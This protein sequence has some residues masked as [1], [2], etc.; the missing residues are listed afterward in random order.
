LSSLTY[1]DLVRE[2]F[3]RLT[4]GIRWGLERTERMLEAVGRPQDRFRA[5]HIGGTN[6]KG[7]V[8]AMVDSVLREAGL[9]TGLYTSPHLCS[10]RERVQIDGGAIGEAE[11]VAAAARLW[12]MIV[13]ESASFFEATTAIAFL[14]L[15]DADVDVAVIEVGLGGRLD[16]TNVVGPEVTVLTNVALDHVQLLGPTIESIARE[17]AGIIKCG[18]P[19]VTG[20]TD[21]I[22]LAIFQAAA[23]ACGTTLFPAA[24]D[25]VEAV[26]T[27][28]RG[29]ALTV[30]TDAWDRLGIHV[31]LAGSHQAFNAA[32]AVRT[33]ERLP[34]DLRPGPDVVQAGLERV[35]WLGRLQVETAAGRTWVFDVAHNM[36]GVQALT[37]AMADLEL[38]RPLVG[39][40]GVLGDKDWRAMLAPVYGFCDAVLLTLPPTAPAE[41]SWDPAAVLAEVPAPHARAVAD[42]HAALVAAREA[43]AAGGGGTILVTG[44]FHTVG[45]ALIA[46]DMT[47][48]GADS[49]LPVRT[50]VA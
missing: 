25:D 33:L 29:T 48:F 32:L 6:G 3:P 1:E 42:F 5:I 45:D 37:A 36:A 39:V 38:P 41:R 40:V 14:A 27:D 28:R 26:R 15:A 16:S 4:G 44:S 19:V 10:F 49:G 9:R 24:P 31:P 30:R 20:E 34:A 12:P 22:P 11:L 13:A 43:S 2:L 35:R 7:S 50:L 21:P 8:A 23:D 17:K 47:P 46:L 18:V